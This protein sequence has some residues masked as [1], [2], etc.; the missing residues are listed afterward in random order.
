[1]HKSRAQ[2]GVRPDTVAIGASAGGVEVA[3]SEMPQSAIGY[4]G[5]VDLV[6]SIMRSQQRFGA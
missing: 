5:P 1:M 2:P 6:D 4:D 3:Y